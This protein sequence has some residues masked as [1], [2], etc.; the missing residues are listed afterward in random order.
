MEIDLNFDQ[1][2]KIDEVVSIPKSYFENSK[3]VAL[4][5]IKVFGKFFYDPNNNI[6]ANINIAG[7]MNLLDDISLEEVEYPFTTSYNDILDE[8]LK[9]SK[10][11]LDLFEL[12]WENIVLEVPLKFTKV[13]NLSEFHGDGWK[14]VSEENITKKNNPFNDLLKNFDKEE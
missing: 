14:L 7:V 13:T 6:Y 5:N 12:L 2:Y 4:N 9:N 1:E 10:N 11:R 8:N 3:V